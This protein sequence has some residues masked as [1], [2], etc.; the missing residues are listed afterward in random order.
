M[1]SRMESDKPVVNDEVQEALLALDDAR[2]VNIRR[3]QRPRRYWIMVGL[4][5]AVFA[6][7]PLTISWPPLVRFIAAPALVIVIVLFVSWKQPTAVRKIRLTGKMWLPVLGFSVFA[8]IV[9]GLN[10]A[11]Y[12][13]YGW[14]WLPVLVAGLLFVLTV[15]AGPVIDRNWART[16]SD[17]VH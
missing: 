13:Q 16:V 5:L 12:D 2:E 10:T 8:G 15:F 7:I 6:L 4:F 17:R 1:L 11:L 9:G 14:W 3:L